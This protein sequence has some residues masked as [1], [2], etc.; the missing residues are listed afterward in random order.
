MSQS[1]EVDLKAKV[2]EFTRLYVNE[3]TGIVK[4]DLTSENPPKLSVWVS[5]WGAM[6]KVPDF[7]NYEGIALTWGFHIPEEMPFVGGGIFVNADEPG[8]PIRRN[9]AD[10]CKC[11]KCQAANQA[12]EKAKAYLAVDKYG[13]AG[14]YTLKAIALLEV[15]RP[16]NKDMADA[17]HQMCDILSLKPARKKGERRQ[18]DLEA[19]A[20]YE[21]AITVL[22]GIGNVRELRGNLTNLGSFYYRIGDYQTALIR[23]LRGLDMERTSAGE[24]SVSPWNH[25]AGCYLAL[26][27]L[28]EAEATI[29]DGFGHCGDSTPM[30]GYLWNTLANITQARAEQYRKRAEVLVPPNSCSIA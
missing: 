26:G 25:V 11:A 16:L 19:I 2:A 22:E 18:L 3:K 30:S 27:R 15:I 12:L 14:R 29:R 23:E 20:W 6:Q 5:D 7:N 17:Y 21:K 10:S 4:A 13:M 24:K 8:P 1:S 28:D 9:H